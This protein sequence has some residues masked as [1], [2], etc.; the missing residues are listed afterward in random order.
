MKRLE[1]MQ[2]YKMRWSAIVMPR[3]I[4]WNGE[5]REN[6]IYCFA[7]PREG[8]PKSDKMAVV[9][10]YLMDN[11]FDMFIDFMKVHLSMVFYNQSLIENNKFCEGGICVD[12]NINGEIIFPPENQ[13]FLSEEGKKILKDGN[14]IEIN[15]DT[16]IG[17]ALNNI[18]KKHR[19]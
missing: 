10:Q 13:D 19:S 1:N 8:N 3:K 9:I 11:C 7:K 5:E 17:E 12:D 6:N 4:I 14:V 2:R 18:F 15:K 16:D